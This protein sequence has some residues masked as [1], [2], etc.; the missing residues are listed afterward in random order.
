MKRKIELCMTL[1]FILGMILVSKKL[2]ELAV[3]AE[4]Q[5]EETIIVIDAGHGGEDPGKVGVNGTLE[6]DVNLQIAKKLQYNLENLG[7]RVVMTRENDTMNGSKREDMKQRVEKI[8]EIMPMLVVSIHQNS[9]SDSSVKGA[10]V[11][12]FADSE[13]SKEAAMVVQQ[14]LNQFDSENTRQ[15]KEN[16]TFFL[17]KKT[18]VPTI[19]VEC[20]FLSNPEDAEKLVQEE[21]QERLSQ[22]ICNGITKWLDK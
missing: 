16:D 8:N 7:F 5:K 19:I 11:F 6:K 3:S 15:L 4:V 18:K 17:L 9:F 22:T 21:Y 12:Y 14:E 2:S 13:E 20:G 1:L 10:Q